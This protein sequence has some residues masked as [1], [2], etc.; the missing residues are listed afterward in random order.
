MEW[1]M[2]QLGVDPSR[3]EPGACIKAAGASDLAG[4]YLELYK[5]AVEMADRISARRGLANS[6]F[7][8]VNTGVTALLGA[9]DMRWY[10]AAAGVVLCA[11]WR[12]LLKSYRALNCAKFNVILALE[13]QL[14]VH[15]YTDEWDRLRRER[16]VMTFRLLQL[17]T[18][19]AQY[20]ELGDIECIVPYIFS[21]IYLAEILRVFVR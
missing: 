7:L 6:Y 12:A 21:V 2:D 13:E 9:F 19:L 1:I 17:R 8:T 16:V 15:V 14:P 20:K 10:L 3:S 18:W 11:A 4:S 5:L